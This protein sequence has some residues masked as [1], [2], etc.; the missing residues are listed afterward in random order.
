LPLRPESAYQ[1]KAA[2]SSPIGPVRRDIHDGCLGGPGN[3]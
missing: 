2:P 1:G 3:R